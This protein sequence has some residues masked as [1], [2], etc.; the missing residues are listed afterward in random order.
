MGFGAEKVGMGN[1]DNFGRVGVGLVG[2][3][4]A[5]GPNIFDGIVGYDHNIGIILESSMT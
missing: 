2:E 5:D 3:E 4:L 1:V